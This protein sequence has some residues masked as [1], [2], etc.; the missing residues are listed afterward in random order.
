MRRPLSTTG[1]AALDYLPRGQIKRGLIPIEKLTL[2]VLYADATQSGRWLAGY[3]GER[4]PWGV[5]WGSAERR[6][7]LKDLT[8]P[9]KVGAPAAQLE[10]EDAS[11]IELAYQLNGLL[12]QHRSQRL[13]AVQRRLELPKLWAGFERKA[14]NHVKGSGPELYA[15]C[16]R[17]SRSARALLNS[18]RRFH[19]GLV[20]F[21]LNWVSHRW[22]DIACV[23]A[24]VGRFR[25][26]Q[27]FRLPE[28]GQ[29]LVGYRGASEFNFFHGRFRRNGRHS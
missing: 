9:A 4:V 3:S 22:R 16:Q 13:P 28:P 24:D 12:E 10:L 5:A 8:L 21:P 19:G 25:K 27:V 17:R 18:S 14:A 1:V 6:Q 15:Q 11:L 20:L 23:F 7:F 2:V 29:D 26:R